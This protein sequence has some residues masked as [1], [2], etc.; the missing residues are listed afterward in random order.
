MTNHLLKLFYTTKD[1]NYRGRQIMLKLCCMLIAALLAAGLFQDTAQA[2]SGIKIYDYATKKEST[3]KDKQVKVTLNGKTVTNTKYPGILV[4]GISLVPYDDV[5]Q[6]SGIAAECTYNKSKGTVSISK[7]GKTITMTIGSTKA[8]LNGQKV[9]LP[10]APKRIKYVKANTTKVLVPSRFISEKLGLTYSW[11]SSTSTVAIVK[12]SMV[13]SY[14]GG[15]KF[16]YTGAQGKV[17]VN[18]KNISLG[19]MPSIIT[20]NT[21]MVRAKKVFTDASIGATYSYNKSDKSVTLTK[22]D[23]TLVMY[24]GKKTAYLNGNAISMDTAPIVVTNHAVKTSYVMVPGGFT[25][26]CL[27]Y[28]YQWNNTTRT[29]VITTQ[30]KQTTVVNQNGSGVAPELG[31]SGALT[32]VGTIL[33]QWI[34]T[35]TAIQKSSG[36]RQINAE[37]NTGYGSVI[38]VERDYTNLKQNAETFIINSTGSFGKVSS[39][40]SDK[41]ITIKAEGMTCSDQT[42]QAYGIFSNFVNTVG[43][44]NNGDNSTSIQFDMP[45][46]EFSYDLSLSANRQSLYVTVYYNTLTSAVIGS[47]NYCDYVTLTGVE[48]L[49]VTSNNSNGYIN[50]ELPYTTCGFNDI[51]T[52]ISGAK[53]IT[54]FN[55]IGGPDKT[56][57]VIGVNE[58]YEYYVSQN[59]NQ[60]SIIFMVP[61]SG[62]AV[63]DSTSSGSGG[64][65][66]GLSRTLDKAFCEIIM[67]KPEGLTSS[68]M[69]DEDNY[70]NHNFVIRLQG[71]YTSVI[72]NSTITNTSGTVTGI[73]VSLNSN[74]ET[75][76]SVN[77]SKLQGYQYGMDDTNIYINIGNPKEIYKNIVILDPGHGGDAKGAEYFGTKEKD[78]NYK[79]LYTIGKKYFNRDSSTLKVYYT[80]IKD[81]D[82]SLSDRAAF[83]SKYGADLFVSLHMNAALIDSAHGTEVYYSTSNNSPNSAGLTS[84]ILAD[85]LA[86]SIPANLGTLRRG[87]KAAKYTVVHKNTVPAVLIE[88][89]FLSNKS[90]HSLLTDENFQEN[91]ARTIYETVLQVLNQYPTGR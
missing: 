44:Y 65:S 85:A 12:T 53:Y 62:G 54:Y 4:N 9:T 1:K 56:Y 34:S 82:M 21:A 49:K 5:F 71:D 19:N 25:A 11:N 24:I 38:T 6:S 63:G 61:G 40:S 60:Y 23:K 58:G 36:V 48:P 50:I 46:T 18:G 13:L 37:T 90:D 22:A 14:D 55:V 89:G 64:N 77:T 39:Q 32:E 20:N 68:M 79:I 42:Y 67:P 88:L 81:V 27:G 57:V 30:K 15:E 76:I 83:A 52:M 7:Y 41:I 3:Y 91:A 87:S 80:R 51:N 26:S 78:L 2:A 73:N 74:N 28:D 10:V 35:D 16:E 59:Q 86:E 45:S 8:T 29:S 47:N 72:N 75:E 17:T 70:F 43:I 33:G 84:K 69:S 31:D 66:G